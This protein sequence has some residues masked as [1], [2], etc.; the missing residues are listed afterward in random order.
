MRR[1]KQV[2]NDLSMA[3]WYRM[4]KAHTVHPDL[5]IDYFENINTK[6]KAYWL[7]FL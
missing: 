2:Q 7:G 5:K 3:Q 6:E 4:W 1:A